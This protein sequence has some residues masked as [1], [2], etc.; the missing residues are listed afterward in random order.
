MLLNETPPRR[1]I[2]CGGRIGEKPKHLRQKQIQLHWYCRGKDGILYLIT[3]LR[4]NSF[5]WKDLK[6]ALHLIPF[7]GESK[8]TLS[9][10]AAQRTCETQNSSRT[11]K[12]PGSTRYSQMWTWEER[13]MNSECGSDQRT[14]GIESYVW[15]RRL[16]RF[17]SERRMPR[18][19]EK[20]E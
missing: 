13:S 5:R 18:E 17:V 4:T 7:E 19:T 9:L 2:R 14:S 6:K 1:N 16:W 12:N 8:H 3:T 11:P 15:F 10:L 20:Y